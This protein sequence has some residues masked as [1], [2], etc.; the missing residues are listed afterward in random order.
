MLDNIYLGEAVE[1]YVKQ[2]LGESELMVGYERRNDTPHIPNS[3]RLYWNR[4]EPEPTDVELE[5]AFH[6]YNWDRA[7]EQR[8]RLL[9][10]TDFYTLSDV[11]MSA[12]MTAYRKDLRDLPASTE[13]SEDV[14]WPTKPAA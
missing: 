7:R 6:I 13:N 2:T 8:N 3:I 12:E 5:A 14:V 10:E 11:T 9:A 4:A 1:A